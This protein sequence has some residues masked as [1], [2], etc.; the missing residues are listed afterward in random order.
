MG[1][2]Q[3]P[4]ILRQL[5]RRVPAILHQVPA[6]LHRVPVI[7]LQL[8]DI[9]H[10]L[11]ASLRRPPIMPRRLPAIL[12]QVP[13][14]LLHLLDIQHRLPAL[15]PAILH[16]LPNKPQQSTR[17]CQQHINPCRPTN[18]APRLCPRFPHF[19]RSLLAHLPLQRPYPA[20]PTPP[21]RFPPNEHPPGGDPPRGFERCHSHEPCLILCQTK[22]QR[23]SLRL[24]KETF[25]KSSRKAPRRRRK[26]GA[27][28]E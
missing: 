3:L 7:L 13:A 18:Q 9:Q 10:Q 4:A 21:F 14:I 16:R 1:Q 22:V 11:P 20:P 17:Q 12:H 26:V 24:M 2:R 25:L 28:Q 6:I 23:M 5:L 15:L 19:H 8:L 27:R